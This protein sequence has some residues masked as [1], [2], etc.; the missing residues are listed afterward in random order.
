[1]RERMA[2]KHQ[3]GDDM[4]DEGEV[5]LHLVAG[6]GSAAVDV[7]FFH[8]LGGDHEKTWTNN[9]TGL[10]WPK[11][12]NKS[13]PNVRVWALQYPSAIFRWTKGG[14]TAV[15][16]T[17]SIADRVR[18]QIKAKGLMQSGGN[19]CVWAC[20]SLGG[21]VAKHVLLKNNRANKAEGQFDDSLLKG[22]MFLGTPHRG[23]NKAD[24]SQGFVSTIKA[25]AGV[26]ERA[27]KGY[28]SALSGFPVNALPNVSGKFGH[29][30]E[31][32]ED[33]EDRNDRLWSLDVQFSQYFGERWNKGKDLFASVVCEG[34]A[35]ALPPLMIVDKQSADP[36]LKVTSSGEAVTP[37]VLP[38]DHG[39]LAKPR[40]DDS[41]LFMLLKELLA[42]LPE[43]QDPYA[44]KLT[45]LTHGRHAWHL[46]H[47][48]AW[49]FSRGR[50]DEVL[51]AWRN[52]SQLDLNPKT[53]AP[54]LIAQ[55]VQK[56]V[57]DASSKACLSGIETV[58]LLLIA[59]QARQSTDR[60]LVNHCDEIVGWLASVCGAP[61]PY[62]AA[63]SDDADELCYPGFLSADSEIDDVLVGASHALHKSW[64]LRSIAHDRPDRVVTSSDIQH[65]R[66]TPSEAIKVED[67][68]ALDPTTSV[69][70]VLERWELGVDVSE[71]E[72]LQAFADQKAAQLHQPLSS[73]DTVKLKQRVEGRHQAQSGIALDARSRP[74]DLQQE[75]ELKQSPLLPILTVVR[76]AADAESDVQV[77]LEQA[78]Q[79]YRSRRSSF[80]S[81]SPAK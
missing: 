66:K 64:P 4:A 24:F 39:Q 11:A 77:R 74:I 42:R 38:L 1:M 57:G 48:V 8:G 13:M 10:Y 71:P 16:N 34:V 65:L 35:M 63:R 41:E 3:K 17:K 28:L 14:A 33:L 36:E 20:H 53:E 30:T 31:L 18:K 59:N 15:G 67:A 54:T 60:E 47:R 52:C 27:A 78:I 80:L 56:I 37:L 40:S 5:T 26:G 55:I 6:D 73:R 51:N 50:S 22:I 62:E 61:L 43:L 44:S 25:V 21:L 79:D 29:L 49:S 12:L 58:G 7:V 81:K 23:S 45:G 70:Q 2:Q 32:I 46:S 9:E 69:R 19:P 76:K 68:A 72:T 75:Q